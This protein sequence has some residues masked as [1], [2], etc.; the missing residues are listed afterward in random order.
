[1]IAV[2]QFAT[3]VPVSKSLTEELLISAFPNPSKGLFSVEIKIPEQVEATIRVFDMQ[4]RVVKT[5]FQGI[6]NE[7]QHRF[8][9]GAALKAGIYLLR[10]ETVLGAQEVI[11]KSARLI[12]TG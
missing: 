8:D 7:G 4:G 9:T 10:A 2:N 5:L 12:V 3:E 1:V 11:L 6:L